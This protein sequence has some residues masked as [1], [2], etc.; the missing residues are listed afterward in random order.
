MILFIYWLFY[1]YGIA[2]S[3]AQDLSTPRTQHKC[4]HNFFY[5]VLIWGWEEPSLF[6]N[7]FLRRFFNFKLICKWH[8]SDKYRI[9]HIKPYFTYNHSGNDC[10]LHERSKLIKFCFH[11]ITCRYEYIDKFVL[12]MIGIQ[13]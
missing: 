6:V 8:L 11:Q 4:H 10:F 3:S 1:L 2:V 5:I 13:S 7:I 9:T 12:W